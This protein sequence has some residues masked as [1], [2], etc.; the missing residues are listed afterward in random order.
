MIG[1]IT[2]RPKLSP[3]TILKRTIA[4]YLYSYTFKQL[5]FS[6]G[7]SE[8]DVTTQIFLFLSYKLR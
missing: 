5:L 2:P 4:Y 3:R 8:I 1:V 7:G 6:K